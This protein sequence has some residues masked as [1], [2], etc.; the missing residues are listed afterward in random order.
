MSMY[1]CMF[2]SMYG[3]MDVSV[4]MPISEIVRD[5]HGNGFYKSALFQVCVCECV[6]FSP[7]LLGI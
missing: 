2:V 4:C 1:V 5:D 3:W 7:F 6:D